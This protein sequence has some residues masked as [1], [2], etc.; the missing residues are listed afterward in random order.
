MKA[1]PNAVVLDLFGTLVGAPAAADRRRASTRLAHRIGSSP[2]QVEDYFLSTW[3]TRHDGTLPT[4]SALAEHLVRW[5][6][7]SAVDADLVADELRAIGSDRLVAD[8]SVVQTLVLL[9]QMGLKVGVLSDATAEISECWET[10]CLAP[11]VD[12]AVFSCTAGATKPDRRLYQAICERLGATANSIVYC[13]DGGGNELC[14][15]HD[16]GM[17][18]LGVVRRGGPDALVFGEKEWNGARI[19][20]IERLP[21]YVASLV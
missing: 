9:R 6:G 14:G 5:V 16:A 10:S 13:G 1:I 15:A 12:A 3:T 11:L 21:T 19:S 2:G 18:A 20:R 17:Q 7:A 4:V 8:E